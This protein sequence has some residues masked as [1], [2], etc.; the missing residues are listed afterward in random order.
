MFDG[1]FRERNEQELVLEGKKSESI[2]ELLKSIYPQFR[3]EIT[4]D[5][6]EDFLQLADEYMIE[7]LK[8]PCKELLV[9]QL[10]TFKHVL[11]PTQQKLEQ[12]PRY[13]SVNPKSRLLPLR[14]AIGQTETCS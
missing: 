3:G 1:E 13:F 10:G 12:V 8:G 4:N 5:N 9:K 14:S 11:L 7:H 2:L 6:V